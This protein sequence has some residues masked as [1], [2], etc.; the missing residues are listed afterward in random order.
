MTS[1]S[2]VGPSAQVGVGFRRRGG[3]HARERTEQGHERRD[4]PAPEAAHANF[5][6]RLTTG[7][8]YGRRDP[9]KG[10]D[11]SGGR[12]ADAAVVQRPRGRG[13]RIATGGEDAECFL[14]VLRRDRY[15]LQR[16]RRVPLVCLLGRRAFLRCQTRTELLTSS[17]SVITATTTT[18]GDAQG[19][20]LCPPW[21]AIGRQCSARLTAPGEDSPASRAERRLQAGSQGR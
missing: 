13:L 20:T 18:A 17:A 21:I 16:L 1:P 9:H 11:I 4:R 5:S 3:A 12:A 2:R 15:G 7:G 14:P 19:T 10:P 6:P 8:A